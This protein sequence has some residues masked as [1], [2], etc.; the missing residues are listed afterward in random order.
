[1]TP[2]ADAILERKGIMVVP[3][4]VANAGGADRLRTSSWA[5][6]LQSFFWDEDEIN[7]RL[8]K[9]MH[10]TFGEVWESAHEH[11][12]SLRHGAYFQA[13]ERVAEATLD[14]GIYP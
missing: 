14:R 9:V 4:V 12:R 8:E 10:R 3:D 7:A 5:Q 2:D 6:D 11:T 1:M 13:I